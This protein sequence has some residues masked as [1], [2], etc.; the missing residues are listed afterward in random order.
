[1]RKGSGLTRLEGVGAK[2]KD[3]PIEDYD[4]FEMIGVDEYGISTKQLRD[5]PIEEF[6]AW[7]KVQKA[8][9]AEEAIK[10]A[11]IQDD[12][13]SSAMLETASEANDYFYRQYFSNKV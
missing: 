8:R 13:M 1:M 11:T 9:K 4:L 2:P 5:T 3:I 6:R 7:A 12:L 10:A